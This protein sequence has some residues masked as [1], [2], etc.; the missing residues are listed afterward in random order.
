MSLEKRQHE[1]VVARHPVQIRVGDAATISGTV[2]NL[3][4][5]GALISTIELEP[6]L[7]V[8]SEL[9]LAIVVSGKGAI[10]VSGQI[11]RVDQEFVG[12]EVRR[13]FAVRFD[14]AIEI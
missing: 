12:G 11:L 1:R 4:A 2:E 5:L 13:A 6:P 3:G 10:E 7:D 14:Q 9:D 8:G